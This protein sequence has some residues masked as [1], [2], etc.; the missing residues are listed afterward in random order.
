VFNSSRVQLTRDRLYGLENSGEGLTNRFFVAVVRTA[1]GQNTLS[2]KLL[3]PGST[4]SLTASF[5]GILAACFVSFSGV[6]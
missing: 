3:G 1:V 4:T 5:S 6:S 2:K